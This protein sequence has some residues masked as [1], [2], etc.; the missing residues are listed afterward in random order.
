MNITLENWLRNK[1]QET[2]EQH[3]YDVA[4]DTVRCWI[5]EYNGQIC[6]C[7]KTNNTKECDCPMSDFFDMEPEEAGCQHEYK[8]SNDKEMRYCI[9]CDHREWNT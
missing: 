4:T 9:Y 3:E 6:P 7:G 2:E 1:L 8:I 5:D